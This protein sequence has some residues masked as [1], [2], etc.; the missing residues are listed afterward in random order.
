PPRPRHRQRGGN[1]RLMPAGRGP[2]SPMPSA[3]S[4]RAPPMPAAAG[5]R[6]CRRRTAQAPPAARRR[7]CRAGERAAAPLLRQPRRQRSA[8]AAAATLLAARKVGTDTDVAGA[9]AGRAGS[10]GARPAAFLPAAGVP[11]V[12]CRVDGSRP[13]S[14]NSR[15]SLAGTAAAAA[16]PALAAG[17]VAPSD[18]AHG[19]L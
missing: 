15:T 14:F 13:I 18:V 11:G 9:V 8:A 4:R 12:L 2:S 10:G 16:A 5:L 3:V 17:P 6:C 7:R 19:G 1:G